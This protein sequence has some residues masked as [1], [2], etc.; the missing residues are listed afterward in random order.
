MT[1]RQ[2]LLRKLQDLQLLLMDDANGISLSVDLSESFI[3]I[4]LHFSG[5]V[6]NRFIYKD[7]SDEVFSD[8][9]KEFSDLIASHLAKNL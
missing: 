7:T 4:S 9:V 2:K 6:K 5:D 1:R 3:Y 8:V